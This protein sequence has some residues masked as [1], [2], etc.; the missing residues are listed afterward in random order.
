M[1]QNFEI[2][3]IDAAVKNSLSAAIIL[4]RG[5]GPDRRVRCGASLSIRATIAA[6]SPRH[7]E[8]TE[9]ATAAHDALR[10]IGNADRR[11]HERRAYLKLRRACQRKLGQRRSA[12]PVRRTHGAGAGHALTIDAER[13]SQAWWVSMASGDQDFYAAIPVFDSFA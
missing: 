12:R 9:M 1:H 3:G 13:A 6:S 10:L 7:C 8:F 11:P 2:V 4:L 5:P